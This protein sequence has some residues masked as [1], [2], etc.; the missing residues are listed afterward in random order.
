MKV[1]EKNVNL[2]Y[3]GT[4]VAFKASGLKAMTIRK[5]RDL[6]E[7]SHPGTSSFAGEFPHARTTFSV[8]RT[9]EEQ[10]LVSKRDE[11]NF[12]RKSRLIL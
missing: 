6:Y 12:R 10:V 8:L 11:H 5:L 4:R 9:G 7:D 2:Q 3:L 1:H